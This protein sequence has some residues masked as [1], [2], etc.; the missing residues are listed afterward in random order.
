MYRIIS[1]D[2]ANN[3][4]KAERLNAT[5]TANSDFDYYFRYDTSSFNGY[6]ATD[7]ANNNIKGGLTMA[8]ISQYD[9]VWLGGEGASAT[10]KYDFSRLVKLKVDDITQTN[11]T[12]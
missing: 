7:K 10:D 4:I 3:S 8:N 12:H 5:Y 9:Y 6:D 11:G 2:A 1:I